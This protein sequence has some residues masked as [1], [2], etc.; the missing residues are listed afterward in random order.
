MVLDIWQLGYPKTI[1]ASLG[2]FWQDEFVSDLIENIIS[3]SQTCLNFNTKM[4]TLLGLNPLASD[5]VTKSQSKAHKT[6]CKRISRIPSI[7][8]LL[9]RECV[10][11]GVDF[12]TEPEMKVHLET[13]CLSTCFSMSEENGMNFY[14]FSVCST[15]KMPYAQ[16]LEHTITFWSRNYG[17]RCSYC[18]MMSTRCK[19]TSQRRNL[20]DI[21][22]KKITDC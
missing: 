2:P 4:I 6:F 9:S 18:E 22:H 16:V 21:V 14:S 11:C 15:L 20:M 10:L 19:C 7:L 8:C 5:S 13:V 17:S 1:P 3:G 12:N